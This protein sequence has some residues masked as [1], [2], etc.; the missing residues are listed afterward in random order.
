[1]AVAAKEL[2]L[3]GFLVIFAAAQSNEAMKT[4]T[5][6]IITESYPLGGVT[7]SGFIG[8]E[9]DAL[10]AEFGRVIIL[11]RV[12][13]GRCFP[14]P[15]NVE[16][17]RCLVGRPSFFNKLSSLVWPETW[18]HLVADLPRIGFSIRR[19]MA[20]LAYSAYVK[21][22]RRKLRRFVK[23]RRMDLDSTL[24]YSFWFVYPVE[25]LAG[26]NG[27]RFV[28][29]A[30]GF[31]VYDARNV[32][33]S[34]S[35]RRSSLR[36]MLACYPV[37]E[38]GA[39]YIRRDSPEWGDKVSVRRLG[40]PGAA[41][42]NPDQEPGD[43][44]RIVSIARV[45]EEKRVGLI[46]ESLKIWAAI[47]PGW[48]I[49]WIHIGDGPMMDCL[50]RDAADAVPPNLYVDL[51]GALPN[52]EVRRLLSTVHFD[53]MMLLSSSE[54]LPVVICEAMSHGI[55]VV[56]TDVGGVSEIVDS[57]VGLLIEADSSAADVA[58]K[59][60]RNHASMRQKRIPA[61]RRWESGFDSVRLRK[62]FAG[63]LKNFLRRGL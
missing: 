14:L 26:I 63:E 52:D 2:C 39:D 62:D 23:R 49:D 30:H 22:A 16:V 15:A 45:S 53:F 41:A 20:A 1:M 11:P 37:S 29:R 47:S 9:I 43:E 46:L 27:A 51:R 59:L 33:L 36:V 54:G 48:N 40:S 19:L 34:H 60:E 3:L 7:E 21:D 44:V 55:P 24:F 31:D 61:R 35:W 50:R 18:N 10:A 56:A 57:D 13:R 12:E 4:T 25:A 17:D 58:G 42:L 32:F 8:P 5:L 38:C 6:V 28:C